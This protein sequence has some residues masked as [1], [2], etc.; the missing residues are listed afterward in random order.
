VQNNI[1]NNRR[2]IYLLSSSQQ[3]ITKNDFTYNGIILSGSGPASHNIPTDNIVNGKPLYYHKNEN[4]LSIDG[5]SVG[6]LILA[7]C[8][9]VLVRNLEIN[10]TDSA[11]QIFGSR[12]VTVGGSD[13]SWNNLNGVAVYSS[14][15]INITQNNVMGNNDYGIYLQ[16]S[17]NNIIGNNV[18]YNER[19]GIRLLFTSNNNITQNEVMQNKW[20][21]IFIDSSDYINVIN[22]TLS[23]NDLGGLGL[24]QVTYHNISNNDFYDDGI[25][26]TGEQ[27]SHHN[28]HTIPTN[29]QVNG[30]PI[31][32]FKNQ[33]SMIIDS[34]PIGQLILANCTDFKALNLDMDHTDSG[35][36]AAFCARINFTDIHVTYNDYGIYLYSSWENEITSCNASYNVRG[37]EITSSLKNNITECNL[38]ENSFYGIILSTSNQNLVYHNNFLN[39]SGQ[40]YDSESDNSWD[41]G[42]P[43][44]GNYWSDYSGSDYFKGPNQDIPGGDEIGDSPYVIDTDSR[45]NYPLLDE[46]LVIALENYTVLRQGWNLISIPLIQEEENLTK[47]LEMIHGYYDAVQRYDPTDSKDPWKHNKIGKPYGNDLTEL[48]ET[49]GFWVHIT[50]PGETIFIYNGTRPSVNQ[51]ITLYPG[52]NMVGYP[53]E[54]VYNRTEA[55]NIIDFGSEVDMIMWYD[56]NSQTWKRMG[57]D[58]YFVYGRGYYIHAKSEC[59]WE[60]PL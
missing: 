54:S 19:T 48:N 50:Q 16:S 37:M 30:K 55:L 3:N 31:Y 47:V 57:S 42:Y 53:S 12:N 2:G 34:I 25:F 33:S 9:D 43:L 17:G 59:F 32:Y 15:D 39:N 38:F 7:N 44:G 40:A 23:S 10:N 28:T 45:D 24:D 51:S 4:N 60:V 36:I 1:S 13:L 49:M 26:I 27:L 11:V 22:N 6:Q 21:G 46:S 14:S 58:D 41:F 52:W 35:V 56:T 20:Q 8:R 18:S 5:I 29:N